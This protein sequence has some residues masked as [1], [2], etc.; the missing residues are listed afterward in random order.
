[1]EL[2]FCLLV[3][4]LLFVFY[5]QK[6]EENKKLER[7]LS[8]AKIDISVLQAANQSLSRQLF[9]GTNPSRYRYNSDVIDAVKYAMVKVHPDNGGKQDDFVKFKHIY[10]KIKED[11]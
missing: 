8:K 7:K 11:K 1:M 9:M 5:A 6:K 4:V 2:L 3:I 10:E